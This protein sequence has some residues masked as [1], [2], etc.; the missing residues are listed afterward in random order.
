MW[1]RDEAPCLL[2]R[3]WRRDDVVPCSWDPT[4][5]ILKW[6]RI[7]MF[8]VYFMLLE[9]WCQRKHLG[10]PFDIRNARLVVQK[11]SGIS[12]AHL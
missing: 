9:I 5:L 3:G 4:V 7:R 10:L 11:A 8:A 2:M 6:K 1:G 12:V